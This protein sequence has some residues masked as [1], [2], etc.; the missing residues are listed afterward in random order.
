MRGFCTVSTYDHLY[1]TLALARS[2]ARRWPTAPR[3][4]VA[5]VDQA[6]RPRAGFEGLA[7]DFLPVEALAIPNFA[8]L[9]AKYDPGDLC[10]A[11][12]P[13]LVAHL[14]AEGCD[15][16]LY[17]DS[18]Q[19]LFGDPSPIFAVEPDA[20]LVATPHLMS[21]LPRADRRCLPRLGDLAYAGLLNAGLFLMRR[22]EESAAFLETW[23]DLVAGPGAFLKELGGQNEQHAFNWAPNFMRRFALWRDP[24]ANVAYWNLHERPVRWAGLDGG[25]PDLWLL[26]G[27]PLVSF[28]FSG[29]DLTHDR[30]SRFSGRDPLVLN[31]NL[32]ALARFY[33]KQLT[34]AGRTYYRCA[35]YGFAALDGFPLT[36]VLRT[37]LRRAELASQP[38]WPAWP[39][40]IGPLLDALAAAP[41]ATVLLPRCLEDI[42]HQRPDLQVMAAHDRI[43]PSAFLEWCAHHLVLEHPDYAPLVAPDHCIVDRQA[44]RVLALRLEAWAPGVPAETLANDLAWRRAERLEALVAAGAPQDA[45]AELRAGKFLIPCY[46]PAQALRFLYERHTALKGRFRDPLGADLAAFR[47]WLGG[48]ASRRFALPA[49]LTAWAARFDPEHSIARMLAAVRQH[50][51]LLTLARQRGFG[52]PLLDAMVELS[53]NG[54]CFDRND[55]VLARWCV[56][57]WLEQGIQGHLRRPLHRALWKA[58]MSPTLRRIFARDAPSSCARGR[59]ARLGDGVAIRL[60]RMANGKPTRG[61]SEIAAVLDPPAPAA[62]EPVAAP[63]GINVFGY[64]KSPIGLGSATTGARDALAL[65]GFATRDITLCNMTMAANLRLRDLIPDFAPEFARNLVVSYPHINYDLPEIFPASY[66]AGRETIGYLAWEQRDLPARW[67]PRLA[68]Y[69]RLFALSRFTAQSIAAASGRPCEPLPCVVQVDEAKAQGFGRA[70]FDLPEDAFL[71]GCFFDASSG[72]ERKNPMGAARALAKA[73]A[74]RRDVLVVLKVTNGDRPQFARII[75]PIV[76]VLQAAGVACRLIPRV[77]RRPEVEG[78]MAALDLYVSLHRSEGFGYTLAEAMWLGVPVIGSAYSGNLDFMSERNSSLVPC[79]ETLVTSSDGPFQIGTVWGDPDL[80][81]AAELCDWAYRERDAALAKAAL[82]RSDIRAFASVEA[83]ARRCR[84]LLGDPTA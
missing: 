20:E 61:F 74:G 32:D 41:G 11:I 43:Q 59:L 35:G 80:G 75:Q 78:L 70:Y 71:V 19:L 40:R 28:H 54:G 69:D 25:D 72:I 52:R 83:V 1:L 48:E 64:F 37:E 16:V 45:L 14:L 53:E 17:C 24:R 15:E 50:P 63:A 42:W 44:L 6:D 31:P 22:G 55:L 79:G 2:V 13:F 8:W 47:S 7:V 58:R 4:T 3:L 66:L 82:A 34:A 27:R 84:A 76:R 65:A 49:S 57:L 62:V 60:R 77:L 33:D 30:L 67:L 21:P 36:P 68:H 81:K 18:D 12:K 51:S 26:D 73:F 38:W 46:L 9:A 56:D 5:L 29:F 10:C 23:S 39:E